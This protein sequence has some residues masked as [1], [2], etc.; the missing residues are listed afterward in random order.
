VGG[1]ARQAEA[2][3][4]FDEGWAAASRGDHA[5][6]VTKLRASVAIAPGA[7]SLA[8][9]GQ[10]LSRLA[11]PAEA[12]IALAAAIG[13]G[14]S[15]VAVRVRLAVAIAGVGDRSEAL[16]RLWDLQRQHPDDP[17]VRVGLRTI[18][19]DPLALARTANR[20]RLLDEIRTALPEVRI[21]ESDTWME[22]LAKVGRY[23]SARA[24]T[25]GD[26]RRL[27][28]A[29]RFLDRLAESPD[30]E[31]ADLLTA[32]VFPKFTGWSLPVDAARA[33]L[34]GPA[35]RALE[36]AL[37]L[38]GPPSPGGPPLAGDDLR[39]SLQFRLPGFNPPQ[40]SVASVG[41]A[42][43]QHYVAS[44]EAGAPT[45]QTEQLTLMLC[46]MADS[47]DGAVRGAFDDALAEVL[48]LGSPQVVRTAHRSL[49]G[50]ARTALENLAGRDQL[51]G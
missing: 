14:D 30:P 16:R 51:E 46:Q 32:L 13:L 48:R 33:A 47:D 8:A 5:L 27:E 28:S 37:A 26:P 1:D 45:G 24:A 43:G 34:G 17:E 36:C 18:L 22:G 19:L 4:L 9:L 23:V 39:E 38:W 6:A 3:S 2:L 10:S 21:G 49:S 12:V 15:T 42:L 50:L 40:P 7:A 11:L 44:V 41:A 31:V 20:W 29:F 25:P 35:R